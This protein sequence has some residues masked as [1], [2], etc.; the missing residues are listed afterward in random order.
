MTDDS[1]IES[2]LSKK[3]AAEIDTAT[4]NTNISNMIFQNLRVQN[5]LSKKIHEAQFNLHNEEGKINFQMKKYTKDWVKIISLEADENDLN[6][7][8][9]NDEENI[10]ISLFKI[11]DNCFYEGHIKLI[12]KLENEYL[13]IKFLNDKI[14]YSITPSFI[15]IKPLGEVIINIKR[16][17]KYAPDQVSIKVYDSL[18]LVVAKTKNKIEDINDA[19]LY[20]RKEDLASPNFDIYIT[21]DNGN[22]FNTYNK[23]IEMRKNNIN[24]FY[25]Q[26]NVN[27]LKDPMLI[28]EEIEKLQKDIKNYKKK[29]LEVHMELTQTYKQ[30]EFKNESKSKFQKENSKKKEIEFNN[31]VFY[32]VDKKNKDIN[33]ESVSDNENIV[34]KKEKPNKF[35]RWTHD[36]NG[37]ALPL[38]M[39]YLS[40]CLFV[41]KIIKNYIIG[42]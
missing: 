3:Q 17:D 35:M 20:V 33:S 14:Y 30:K 25:E 42:N 4:V 24:K 37:I 27:G 40:I 2:I 32:E 19:I 29:I 28:K 15:F 16:F 7:L 39:F 9:T 6:N 10:R 26:L 41:G 22:D 13:I 23:V 1:S 11:I 34:K 8:H 36:E 12:N 18:S 38:L 21:L 31:E 5:Q